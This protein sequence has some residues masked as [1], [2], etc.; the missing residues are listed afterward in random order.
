LRP[1]A[2]QAA[3]LRERA[4]ELAALG[5]ALEE[6]GAGALLVRG[7]PAGLERLDEEGIHALLDDALADA[8]DWRQRLLSTASCHAAVKKGRTLPENAAREPPSRLGRA[9][10]PAVCPHGS[11]VVLHLSGGMLKRLFNW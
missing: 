11:P 9:Q 1:A 2:A 6:F 3:R 7:A 8:A 10:S 4:E 5:W